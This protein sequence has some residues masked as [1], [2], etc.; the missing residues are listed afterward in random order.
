M[1]LILLHSKS[2]W[3]LIFADLMPV[4]QR[5]SAWLFY[6]VPGVDSACTHLRLRYCYPSEQSMAVGTM[7]TAW[8][9]PKKMYESGFL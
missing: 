5:E 3:P 8:I 4:G 6:D 7:T 9:A 1:P 2:I